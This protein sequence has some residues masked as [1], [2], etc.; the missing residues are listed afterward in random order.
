[1]T[2]TTIEVWTE[3]QISQWE[4]EQEEAWAREADDLRNKRLARH[5]AECRCPD[6]PHIPGGY[7]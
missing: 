3:E 7:L 5:P 6:C 2:K 1:M 4:R